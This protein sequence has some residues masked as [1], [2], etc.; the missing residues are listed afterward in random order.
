MSCEICQPVI[1]RIFGSLTLQCSLSWITVQK[2]SVRSR[3]LE[4]FQ[5][6][7]SCVGNKVDLALEWIWQE[8]TRA[9]E[10]ERSQALE[11]QTLQELRRL[12]RDEQGSDPVYLF[13]SKLEHRSAFDFERFRRDLR[14]AVEKTRAERSSSIREWFAEF[15]LAR[16]VQASSLRVSPFVVFSATCFQ[17]AESRGQ[18]LQMKRAMSTRCSCRGELLGMRH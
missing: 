13:S 10:D 17:T 6:P 9:L 4:R 5:V 16:T 12:F 7:C 3:A 14:N 1:G 11:Q 8:T 18:E 15:W 2:P